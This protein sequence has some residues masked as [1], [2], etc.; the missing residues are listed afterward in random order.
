[1]A[2][3]WS[4]EARIAL[5][6][7]CWLAAGHEKSVQEADGPHQD[8]FHLTQAI[9]DDTTFQCTTR[10]R[11]I[12]QLKKTAVWPKVLPFL[13]NGDGKCADCKHNEWH[14]GGYGKNSGTK[15]CSHQPYVHTNQG[16]TVGERCKC[17]K[18]VR[19]PMK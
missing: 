16:S 12:S 7:E 17:K 3:G 6:Y 2:T 8:W 4:L 14:H 13:S 11:L 9:L 18:F 19:K 1:M 10:Q 5:L 15:A